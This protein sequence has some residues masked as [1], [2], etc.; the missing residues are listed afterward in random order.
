M[1][2][3]LLFCLLITSITT[4]V[5]QQQAFIEGDEML[6]PN[7]T[8]TAIVQSFVPYDS[9]Q[10]QVKPY[11]EETFTN[12][13]GAT[14]GTFTYDAYTYSVT[15]IRVQVTQGGATFFS[16]ELFIDSMA[17]LPIFYSSDTSGN[18]QINNQ[19]GSYLLCP[20]GSIT[21]Q[22]MGNFSS[23]QWY[24]NDVA[25][26]GATN[27]TYV[28]T[29]PGVYYA[30]AIQ[31]DCPGSPENTLPTVVTASTNCGPASL[32]PVIEGE[33]LLCPQGNG[34]AMVVSG[35]TYDTYQWQFKF[36]FETEYTDVEGATGPSF[37]Y[38]QYNYAVTDIRVK[39]TFEG[40]TYYSNA[41]FIDSIVFAGLLVNHNYNPALV[42]IEFETGYFL[43]CG[44][45]AQITNTVGAPYTIVQWYKDG[46]PVEGATDTAFVITEPGQYY[47]VAAPDTCPDFVETLPTFTVAYNPECT[48]GLGDVNSAAF[49]LYPNP[50]NST[51]NLSLPQS[52]TLENYTIVDVTGKTL[53][54][55]TLTGSAPSINIEA[56]ATGSYIIKVTGQT[57]Q[58][59]KLFVKQ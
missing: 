22:V 15:Y 47:V 21:N 19:D 7:G 20:G 48:A 35:P 43:L 10:W 12:I 33:T 37:T 17:F 45:E 9:Y 51:L 36:S 18:V 8:G 25:I 49:S 56:L 31:A 54:N 11:G 44:E 59:T 41:L 1:K 34:T 16:N 3:Y 53:M 29:Q 55:G 39:V 50:A 32:V 52:T 57:T 30:S 5:A 4:S 2:I 14:S 42:S 24:N 26:A 38:D 13:A 40:Q 46:E 28:I 6:C 23:I 58:A 27:A